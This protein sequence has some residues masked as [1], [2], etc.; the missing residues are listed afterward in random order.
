ME[1][2]DGPNLR[3]F[4]D[5]YP[6]PFDVKL[7]LELT[8]G[9]AEGLG[10]A[11]AKGMVHR[12][13]KPE[14]VLM[15]RERGAWVPKI[16]DF[17]IVATK[18]SS[19][20]RTRT[21]ASLLTWAYA[22]PEQWIGMKAAELDG[23]TDLYALGGVLFEML[24]SQTAFDAE[25]YE[26]WA[27]QHK[28]SSPRPPSAVR[29]DLAQWRGLDALVLCLLAKNSEDRPRDVA[30]LLRLLDAIEFA[31][32]PRRGTMREEAPPTPG[33]QASP[34]PTR[35][36]P[37]PQPPPGRPHENGLESGQSVRQ[38]PRRRLWLFLM[39]VLVVAGIA[40]VVWI[41]NRNPSNS[42]TQTADL[43]PQVGAKAPDFTV[44]DGT[45]S[46]HL[47]G[48]RGRVVLLNFWASWAMPC[49]KEL[50]L[51]S[52]LQHDQPG[53]AVLAVSA[54]ED[55]IAYNRFLS[56]NRLHL[57]TVRDPSQTAPK[58]YH[59]DKWPETWIIDRQGVI[60]RRFIGIQNWSSP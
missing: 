13:I 23:R 25:S 2:V 43:V 59:S 10:A 48:Y 33:R 56:E 35:F 1:F 5:R 11:H 57:T 34:T 21:G 50:P 54:D 17:G 58:L 6:M 8:R 15:V 31:P 46:V 4:L 7:A 3:D 47:A 52:K 42:A 39:V 38:A 20:T 26:G 55:P 60:R 16:A 22:A 19:T 14:N 28:N 30:E 45:S 29:P 51:L 24:T 18:E 40:A 9:I 49:A 36:E 12:D 37:L 53:L 44:S 27:E 32:Q 41:V